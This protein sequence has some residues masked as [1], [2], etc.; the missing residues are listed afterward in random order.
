MGDND[1]TLSILTTRSELAT[2]HL[3]TDDKCC[4]G[5]VSPTCYLA[6]GSRASSLRGLLHHLPL[7][8]LPET[9]L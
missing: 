7:N 2:Q 6:Q 9:W 8:S 1:E 4:F 3:F 5:E